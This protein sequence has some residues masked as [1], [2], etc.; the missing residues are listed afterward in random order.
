M[1]WNQS[2]LSST[3]TA[4]CIERDRAAFAT[5]LL[6]NLEWYA[7]YAACQRPKSSYRLMCYICNILFSQKNG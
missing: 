5:L 4:A 7:I 2:P 3:D 1:R 6:H